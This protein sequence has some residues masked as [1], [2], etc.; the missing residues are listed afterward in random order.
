MQ[1]LRIATR[2]SPLALWQ[3]NFVAAWLR[4]RTPQA[5]ELIEIKT[6]GDL[7][8]KDTLAHIGGVGVFTKEIQ[9]AV[10]DGRADIAVHSLK[11][12]PTEPAADLALAAI[13]ERGSTHDA[14]VSTRHSSFA[15]LPLGARVATGSPRRRAQLLNRRPDLAIEGLRGNVD[16]RLRKLEEEQLDAIIL[17]AA[18]LE[19]LG[20]AERIA[21]RLDH[22]WM[23]PAVGQ[24]A[25]AVECRAEDAATRALLQDLNHV[26]TRAAVTAERAV[27]RGL[28][29]GCLLP[30]AVLA[31][32]AGDMLKLRA[33]LFGADGETKTEREATGKT[34]EAE[35]LGTRVAAA[36]RQAVSAA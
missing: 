8:Q 4:P 12:L 26:P 32:A 19:R 14:L 1:T 20:L 25:L 3:A 23:L 2:G 10:L 18:G 6:S 9:R 30:L 11:D 29:G 7:N 35:A 15:A 16:T 36:L 22:A 24:G 31:S 5:V 13:P 17:A 21:E 27:L 33:A 34:G 28:G